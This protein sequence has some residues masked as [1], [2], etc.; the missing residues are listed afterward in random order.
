MSVETVNEPATFEEEAAQEER[1]A[2]HNREAN[3]AARTIVHAHVNRFVA[4]LREAVAEGA[5]EVLFDGRYCE[6]RGLAPRSKVITRM[7]DEEV[8]ALVREIIGECIQYLPEGYE[9]IV[10]RA[11]EDAINIGMGAPPLAAE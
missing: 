7:E 4:E 8:A 11:R 10:T 2:A 9:R 3:D 6:M 5:P 1:E